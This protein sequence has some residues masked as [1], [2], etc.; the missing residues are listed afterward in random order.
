MKPLLIDFD[1]VI[2]LGKNFAPDA[3]D[4]LRCIDLENIPVLILSNSSLLTGADIRKKISDAG[5]PTSI[6][7]MTTVD[8]AYAMIKES[9]KKVTVHC[10]ESVKPVFQ[11]FVDDTNP[12]LIVI[13]DIGNKWTYEILN[14]IFLQVRNGAKILAL[15]KNK[16]WSPDG[17]EVCLDAGTFIAAIEY[18]TGINSILIGKPSPLYFTNAL[19]ALGLASESEFIM[20]GDD[21]DTDI[22]GAKNLG[23]TGILI[24]TGK[25]KLP[26]PENISHKPDYIVHN[27]L[28]AVEV[29]RRMQITG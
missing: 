15:H 26:L 7:V 19:H 24:L 8:A 23:G 29:L 27:L 12:E 25:T 21:L 1:G 14:T 28:E 16:Y 2:R 3:G 9:G 6:P 11:E 4:F 22:A 18:A 10:E 20:L 13:G 5:F 17:G